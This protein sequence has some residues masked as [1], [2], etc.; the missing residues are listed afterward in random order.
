MKNEKKQYNPLK[1]KTF[2][3][4]YGDVTVGYKTFSIDLKT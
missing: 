1:I 2:K 4:V 3:P